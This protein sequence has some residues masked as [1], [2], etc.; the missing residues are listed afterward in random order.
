MGARDILGRLAAAG[1][2]LTRHGDKLVAVPREHLDDELRVLI[3]NHKADL[4]AALPDPVAEARRQRV[5]SMLAENRS[6]TY[7]AITDAESDPGSILLSLAIRDRASCELR[8]PRAK[9]DPFLLLT[10]LERHS[11]TIH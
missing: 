2:R 8:I 6:I 11:G 5:L 9:Y 1:V 7:A 3:R 4:M 10:L